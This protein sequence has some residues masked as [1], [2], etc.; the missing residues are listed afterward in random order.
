MAPCAPCLPIMATPVL[1]SASRTLLTAL[2]LSAPRALLDKL[3]ALMDRA[4]HLAPRI[5]ARSVHALAH[6]PCL[7]PT[8]PAYLATVQTS[9]TLWPPTS[10]SRVQ[11]RVRRVS[12]YPRT[13]QHGTLT[14]TH[15]SCGVN[16][17]L[18]ITASWRSRSLLSLHF[19]RFTARVLPC[20]FSGLCTRALEKR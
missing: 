4:G 5:W 18:L 16:A 2:S 7:H 20:S 6:L 9:T 17:L 11:R 3:T 10:L 13:C 8:T 15:R 19:M 14:E 1:D 12:M